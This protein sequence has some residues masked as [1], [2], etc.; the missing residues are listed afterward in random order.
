MHMRNLKWFCRVWPLN[1][2]ASRLLPFKAMNSEAEKLKAAVLA[3]RAATAAADAATTAVN[4]ATSAV[5]ALNAAKASLQ[6]AVIAAAQWQQ[7][8]LISDPVCPR[9]AKRRGISSQARN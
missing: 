3:M 1:I 6:P 9:T 7:A 8:S 2:L 4:A 5:A